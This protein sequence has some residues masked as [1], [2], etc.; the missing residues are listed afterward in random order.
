MKDDNITTGLACIG[1]VAIFLLIGVFGSIING[2]VLSI[3][4]QWFVVPLFNLPHLSIPYA[5]GI[6]LIVSVLKS[7]N[8]SHS[9]PKNEEKKDTTT[10]LAE[11]ISIILFVPLFILFLGWVVTLFM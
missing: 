5:I 3:L 4:W 7:S 2:W 1:G 9:K 6:S 11:T 8:L 10:L